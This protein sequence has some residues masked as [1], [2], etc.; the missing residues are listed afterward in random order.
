MSPT[1]APPAATT[2]GTFDHINAVLSA[3]R[4]AANDT[5]KKGTLSPAR[6]ARLAALPG[7]VWTVRRSAPVSAPARPQT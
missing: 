4:G 1:S 7:W 2:P 3:G 6:R 5:K